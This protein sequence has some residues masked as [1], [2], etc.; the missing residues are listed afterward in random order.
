MTAN[1]QQSE[2]W[3]GAESVHYVDQAER[4]DRQLEP[5]ADALFDVVRLEPQ[6]RC[7]T[8]AAVAAL[9]RFLQPAIARSALGV[10]LSKPLLEVAASRARAESVD[11]AEFVAAD[12]A[13][14]MPSPRKL[15]TS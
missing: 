9:P 12:G 7:L 3:N 11:N 15:P 14:P 8:W 2:A 10:D 5:I 1:Q 4:Y 6:L 13:I